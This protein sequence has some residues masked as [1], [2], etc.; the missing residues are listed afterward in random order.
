MIFFRKKDVSD[1]QFSRFSGLKGKIR[2]VVVDCVK[3]YAEEF[4]KQ[5]DNAEKKI[6]K[7]IA[8]AREKKK[9]TEKQEKKQ[10]K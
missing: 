2:H 7:D 3:L 1:S 10:E 5:Y 4:D 9:K 6:K 8:E